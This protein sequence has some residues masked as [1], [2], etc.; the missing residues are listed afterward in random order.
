MRN[1]FLCV[2]LVPN[3]EYELNLN[4]RVAGEFCFFA[5]KIK[6]NHQTSVHEIVTV[7]QLLLNSLN[8]KKGIF[9][10]FTKHETVI[11]SVHC[12]CLIYDNSK[13]CNHSDKTLFTI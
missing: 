1:I 7:S 8:R 12:S 3:N 10:L 2:N 9:C 11:H 4:S 13:L 5:I 6:A